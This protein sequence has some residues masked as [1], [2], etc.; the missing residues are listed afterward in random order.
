MHRDLQEKIQKVGKDVTTIKDNVDSLRSDVVNLGSRITEAEERVSQLED[1]NGR[2]VNTVTGKVEQL[3]AR[4]EYHENYSRRNNLWIKEVP[5]DTEHGDR[6][7][8]CVN[9]LL[10]CLFT[11]SGVTTDD[12]VIERAHRVP[13]SQR[14]RNGSGRPAGPRYV[15]VRFLRFTDREKVRLRARDPGSWKSSRISQE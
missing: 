1:E 11:N 13:T 4:V 15:L 5:Q 12:M 7:M 6:V 14:N 9:D 10:R 3:E 2:L 8:D